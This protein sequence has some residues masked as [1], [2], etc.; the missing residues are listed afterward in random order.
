MLGGMFIN[1]KEIKNNKFSV[2]KVKDRKS[3]LI[4]FPK[5]KNSNGV[6]SI[7]KRFIIENK[8]SYKKVEILQAL[9]YLNMSP[10]HQPPFSVGLFLLA[11]YL[12]TKRIFLKK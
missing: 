10:L 9:I 12:L 2:K 4:N 8:I 7:L 5:C 6:I 3:Y 1:Y 11:K